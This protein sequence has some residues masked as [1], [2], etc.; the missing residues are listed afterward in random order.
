MTLV[1]RRPGRYREVRRGLVPREEPIPVIAGDV[2]TKH[3]P[4]DAA[5]D[6]WLRTLV[7]VPYGRHAGR[8]EG[9]MLQAAD[10]RPVAIVTVHPQAVQIRPCRFLC[11]HCGRDRTVV[12]SPAIDGGA[13]PLA[14]AK[15]KESWIPD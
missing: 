5:R 14:C 12:G 6:R 7:L 15:C 4:S 3:F 13:V 8:G 10:G 2:T 9:P 1:S 11:P